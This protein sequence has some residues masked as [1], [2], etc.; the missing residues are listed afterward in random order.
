MTSEQ[1]EQTDLNPS[2]P[3]ASQER[4]PEPTTKHHVLSVA[5]FAVKR[6]AE[7]T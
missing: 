3:A 7:K 1:A 4:P 6:V 5:R 2:N